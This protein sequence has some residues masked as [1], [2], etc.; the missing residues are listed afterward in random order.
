MKRYILNVLYFGMY[1]LGIFNLFYCIRKKSQLI[2]TYHHVITDKLFDENLIHLG[3]ACSEAAFIQQLNIILKRFK[4]T[5]EI[6][7][8][9]S[10]VLTFDDGYKNNIQIASP[11][12]NKKNVQAFFFVPACYFSGEKILW[13]DQVLLWVSYIPD[14]TYFVFEKPWSINGVKSRQNLWIF[15]YESILSDYILASD[16]IK[17][18]SQIYSFEKLENTI[19]SQMKVTRLRL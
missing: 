13:V 3:V 12:L 18:L 19:S 8:A 5:T 6:G 15:L 17:I 11:I 7:V 2:L 1:Y 10:C 14:G 4:T 9:G 16:I